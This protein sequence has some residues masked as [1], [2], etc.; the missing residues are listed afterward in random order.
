MIV[1][2]FALLVSVISEVFVVLSVEQICW[3]RQLRDFV[4]LIRPKSC[5]YL[6]IE[7]ASSRMSIY[8]LS[9]PK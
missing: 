9:N 2:F 1:N 5:N 8:Y 6:I 3:L 7:T 4:N